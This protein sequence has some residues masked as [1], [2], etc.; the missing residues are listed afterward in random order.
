[1]KKKSLTIKQ[2]VLLI[3]PVIFFT[4]AATSQEQAEVWIH[5]DVESLHE[6]HFLGGDPPASVSLSTE[7]SFTHSGYYT[8]SA[9]KVGTH[10]HYMAIPRQDPPGQKQRLTGLS[11]VQSHPCMDN[12][13]F[14]IGNRIRSLPAEVNQSS[15]AIEI[16]PAGKERVKIQLYPVEV[17][18][19]TEECPN[20]DCLNGFGFS[21][22][23]GQDWESEEEDEYGYIET[24]G[25]DLAE[26][27]YMLLKELGT[28]EIPLTIPVSVEKI[29]KVD[30][31][32]PTGPESNVYRFRVTGW[33]GAQPG[34]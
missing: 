30:E 27:E 26:V 13:G 19:E 29:Y 17:Y 32:T 11:M 12:Q 21:H 4:V 24:S 1:M 34:E 18:A 10:Y 14:L 22:I 23:V 9:F 15:V 3:I 16:K 28:G 25:Y 7:I 31:D 2:A 6:H 33:I 5:L 20:P 8:I